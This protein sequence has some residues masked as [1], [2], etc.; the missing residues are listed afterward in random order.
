MNYYLEVLQE[1]TKFKG[2]VRRKKYWMFTLVN[3][4]ITFIL[5]LTSPVLFMLY[6]LAVLLPSLGVSVR[7]LHDTNPSGWWILISSIAFIGAIVMIIFLVQDSTPRANKYG[8]NP[9]KRLE[10]DRLNISKPKEYK[11]ENNKE[12]PLETSQL[13]CSYCGE[14]VSSKDLFCSN[15]GSK[16][17]KEKEQ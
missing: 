6:S 4:I 2:R 8:P 11:L 1:Y 12:L 9:K 10:K 17:I 3:F 5:R 16:I 15:C 7:R 13:E 14:V